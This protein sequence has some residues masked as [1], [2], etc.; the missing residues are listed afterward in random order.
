MTIQTCEV[1]R[2]GGA[3]VALAK[4]GIAGDNCHSFLE[5]GGFC[6]LQRHV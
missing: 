5:A 4:V 1:S 6:G 3:S 2:Q